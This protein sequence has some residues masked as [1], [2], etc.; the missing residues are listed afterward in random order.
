MEAVLDFEYGTLTTLEL[1]AL[2]ARTL[3]TQLMFFLT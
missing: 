3:A 2:G 1:L